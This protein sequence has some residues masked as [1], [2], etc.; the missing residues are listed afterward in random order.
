[1]TLTG[2]YNYTDADEVDDAMESD[3]PRATLISL[4]VEAS[5]GGGRQDEGTQ[6]RAELSILG[7]VATFPNK[8]FAD[9]VL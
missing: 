4:L 8:I 2:S 3:D 9:I 7:P 5:S 1:M 6:L